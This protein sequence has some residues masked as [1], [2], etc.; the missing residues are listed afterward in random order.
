MSDL[1]FIGES[2]NAL[3]RSREKLLYYKCRVVGGSVSGYVTR[4][5]V[6]TN[7]QI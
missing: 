4:T 7:G 6:D 5:E 2:C 3:S 1:L